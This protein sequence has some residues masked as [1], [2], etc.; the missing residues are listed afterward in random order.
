MSENLSNRMKK[1]ELKNIFDYLL[2]KLTLP[3]AIFVSFRSVFLDG[4]FAGDIGD[5]R[6]NVV[7][8]DHWYRVFS[9]KDSINSYLVFYPANNVVGNS[10]AFFLQGCLYTFIHLFGFSPVKSAIGAEM[11]FA[12]IGFVG[13]SKFLKIIIKNQFIRSSCILLIA[14]SY[15]FITAMVHPQLIGFLYVFWVA[16]FTIQSI[17]SKHASLKYFLMSII[18]CEILALSSWTALISLI[19]YTLTFGVVYLIIEGWGNYSQK[20][21]CYLKNLKINL[22][23][24]KK[25]PLILLSSVVL[26]LG[27]LWLKIYFFNIT[28]GNTKY[29]FTEITAY[30]PRYGDI[31]NASSGAFGGWIK[32]YNYFGISTSPTGERALGYPPVLLI[33]NIVL[34]CVIV[35]R[36]KKTTLIN[37]FGKIF[38][39]TN[40]IV[41]VLIITDDANRSPWFFVYEFVPILGSIRTLFRINILLTFILITIICMVL[42]NVLLKTPRKKVAVFSFI[43]V[44]FIESIRIYPS[45]WKE[46]DY[47]PY[48]A[49]RVLK[50]LRENQCNSFFLVSENSDFNPNFH[51]N[52]AA[53]ISV[54]SGIPTVNGVSSIF[55]PGWE[56]YSV[57]SENYRDPLNKWISLNKLEFDSNC[58]FFVK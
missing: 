23:Q 16:Y 38:L 49:P 42:E 30:S 11:L 22:M 54:E 10:D 17:K 2:K 39:T 45:S 15:P 56:L 24:T 20:S 53:A 58:V 35:L 6:G 21:K 12:F 40:F 19:I 3:F 1:F 33:T 46:S 25:L 50:E 43:F 55:P 28:Q 47:L 31:A 32:L 14:N 27:L 41:L 13:V 48:Y 51:A 4:T 34:F 44:L 29:S 36:N 8:L 37:N 9:G 57:N 5:A 52:N 18:T 26:A 7:G